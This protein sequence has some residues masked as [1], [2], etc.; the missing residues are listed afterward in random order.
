[1]E[2]KVTAQQA[3]QWLPRLNGEYE[4]NYYAGIIAERLGRAQ[5]KHQGHGFSFQAYECFAKP[6]SI[7]KKRKA[8]IPRAMTMR[9]SGGMPAY[10]R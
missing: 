10:E 4:R 7:S 6:W 9:F 8:F 2:S 1:M 3:Q 5:M